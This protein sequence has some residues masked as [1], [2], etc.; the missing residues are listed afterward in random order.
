MRHFIGERLYQVPQ[1]LRVY[2][3][4]EH[5]VFYTW[6]VLKEREIEVQQRIYEDEDDLIDR[7]P[8]FEFDFYTIYAS[9]RDP[10]S[11]IENGSALVAPDDIWDPCHPSKSI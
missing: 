11:L 9:G 1:I 6:V 10:D 7:F 8:E 3:Q 5:D 4:F 2:C